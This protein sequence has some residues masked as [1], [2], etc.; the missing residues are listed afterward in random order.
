[1]LQGAIPQIDWKKN[2]K[3]K[4]YLIHLIPVV[5]LITETLVP[6]VTVVLLFSVTKCNSMVPGRDK[7]LTLLP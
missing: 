3:K 7:N 6:G 5:V 4:W 2:Q 1:L